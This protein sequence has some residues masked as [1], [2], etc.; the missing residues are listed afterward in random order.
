MTCHR[1][2]LTN[3]FSQS[4]GISYPKIAQAMECG[5]PGETDLLSS[6]HT[7]LSSSFSKTWRPCQD[8]AVDSC[9][10]HS[11]LLILLDTSKSW[12]SYANNNHSLLHCLSLFTLPQVGCPLRITAF[13]VWNGQHYSSFR[14]MVMALG[15]LGI[16]LYALSW[17]AVLRA[18][19]CDMRVRS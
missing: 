1:R 3:I 4:F 6:G 7:I 8:S 2:I 11:R 14:L 18:L 12:V 10:L 13:L 19:A 5:D 9:L 17:E 16:S 15:G